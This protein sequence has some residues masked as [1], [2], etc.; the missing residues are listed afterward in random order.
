MACGDI[1][2]QSRFS[3]S[4][5]CFLMLRKIIIL[6]KWQNDFFF[7]RQIFFSWLAFYLYSK[8]DVFISSFHKQDSWKRPNTWTKYWNVEFFDKL[9]SKFKWFFAEFH[10][11]RGSKRFNLQLDPKSPKKIV[12]SYSQYKKILIWVVLY[13]FWVW[14]KNG[15]RAHWGYFQR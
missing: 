10:R 8:E 1:I 2:L 4:P 5:K 6:I 13:L 12:L 7:L 9:N 11:R 15:I 3:H 14:S